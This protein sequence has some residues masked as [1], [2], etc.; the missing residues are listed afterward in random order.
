MQNQKAVVKLIEEA[1]KAM[2]TADSASMYY[3]FPSHPWGTCPSCGYCPHCGR[4][5]YHH[6]PYWPSQPIWMNTSS[7][8][9][10]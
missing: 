10:Q 2:D 9:I 7:N 1:R 5:G 3:P 8:H 4:G 6:A